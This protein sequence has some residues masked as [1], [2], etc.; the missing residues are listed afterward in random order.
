MPAT[1]RRHHEPG[2]RRGGALGRRCPGARQQRRRR[3]A[4]AVHG[5]D[6]RRVDADGQRQL[7]RPVRRHACRAAADDRAAVGHIV[8]IGSISGRS[9]FVGGTCYAATKHAAMAFSESLMLELR[10]SGVKVSVVNP[11]SVATN[12][13]ERSDKSW[14][15]TAEDVAEAVAFM[16]HHAAGRPHPSGGDPDVDRPRRSMTEQMYGMHERLVRRRTST[17]AFPPV[18]RLFSHVSG[19]RSAARRSRPISVCGS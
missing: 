16:R 17:V 7:Q 1:S 12:F 4:Q 6:A 2:G 15:L 13:S 19:S 10:D 14:M 9:A 8:I 5:A 3:H 18:T 11:G